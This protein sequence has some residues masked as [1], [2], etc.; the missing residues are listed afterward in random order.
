MNRFLLYLI[1]L[2]GIGAL[3]SCDSSWNEPIS[4]KGNL[5]FETNTSSSGPLSVGVVDEDIFKA[6]S[7]DYSWTQAFSGSYQQI[8]PEE[9]FYEFNKVPPGDYMIIAFIDS[10][11]NGRLDFDMASNTFEAF[12]CYPENLELYHFDFPVY[13]ASIIISDNGLGFEYFDDPYDDASSYYGSQPV[14]EIKGIYYNSDQSLLTLIIVFEN[15]LKAPTGGYG[16][17][18]FR[19]YLHLNTY[20]SPSYPYPFDYYDP[21]R[22][23]YYMNYDHLIDFSTY[24]DANKSV[25]LENN[26]GSPAT[27]VYCEFK[28]NR[29]TLIIPLINLGNPGSYI[30]MGVIVSNV[31]DLNYNG[32]PPIPHY[33]DA[34]G[35]WSINLNSAYP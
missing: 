22:I 19:G 8:D 31:F 17:E 35:Q 3:L 10:N 34:A 11:D 30:E 2:S 18:D 12:G 16:D 14:N 27:L 13:S 4:I 1:I 24:Y 29:I 28:D 23:S 15:Y 6:T 25:N 32:D 33:Q 20:T 26:S 21:P 7:Q 9:E 5:F